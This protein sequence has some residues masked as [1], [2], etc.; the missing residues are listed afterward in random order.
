[1]PLLRVVHVVSVSQPHM[2]G[3]AMR[4]RY[5]VEAQR[6]SGRVSPVVVTSPFWP[7]EP[8]SFVSLRAGSVRHVRVPHPI[9][10]GQDREVLARCCARIHALRRRLRE[11]PRR[12]SDE[13]GRM[14]S[15]RKTAAMVLHGIEEVALLRVFEQRLVA[16]LRAERPDVV[17][18]H[19]PY[20]CGLPALKACRA[21]GLP[22]VYEVRGLWEESNVAAG[23][24]GRGLKYRA[25]RRWETQVMR[26]ADAVITICEALR[27]EVVSRGVS[28]SR[29][30]VVPNA[31]D[32]E[33]FRPCEGPSPSG[34][35]A[36]RELR[37]RLTRPTLGYVG[38]LRELEGVEGLIQAVAILQERGVRTSALIV[39]DGV[40]AGP[41]RGAAER[42][43]VADRVVFTGRVAHEQ[44]RRYYELIDIFVV[45]RPSLPVTRLVTPLKPL[46]AM[47][48][49]KAVILP[50]LEALREIV[51]D[52]VT[53]LLYAADCVSSLADRCATLLANHE[54]CTELGRAA[55]SWVLRSRTW[56]KS[57]EETQRA[58]AC[59]LDR[60]SGV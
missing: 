1:M 25:W 22:L 17:H 34:D 5:I 60:H 49:G 15:V 14:A 6:A 23:K 42:L 9:D 43:G 58:Y 27:G 46:E 59:A 21:L 36:L 39:G 47:A 4:T 11:R 54:L 33:T 26:A 31:V 57:V 29:V 18:A 8:A 3:Y 35:A 16:L 19:S 44:V 13:Q 45:S 24:Y 55:R 12:G 38:T 32:P 48:M 10:G 52:G 51:E 7:G 2:S 20:R 28:R 56:P 37:G 30:F 41:L 40:S 50:D 53:G